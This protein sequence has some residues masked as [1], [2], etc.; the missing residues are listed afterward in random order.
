MMITEPRFHTYLQK[1][2][3]LLSIIQTFKQLL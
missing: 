2:V 1:L 3:H